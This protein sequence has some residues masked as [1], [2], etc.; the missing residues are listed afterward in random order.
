MVTFRGRMLALPL[1]ALSLV[2]VAGCSSKHAATRY[3]AQGSN[4]Y[5]K[6]LPSSGEGGLAFGPTLATA[7][8]KSLDSC[9]RYASRSGGTPRT[10]QVVVAKCK[11]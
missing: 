9:V 6:A 5:A 2:L 3:A 1:L 7:S 4:C 8:R 10:C 11:G